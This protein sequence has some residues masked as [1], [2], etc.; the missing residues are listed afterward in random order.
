[1]TP[2]LMMGVMWLMPPAAL[3]LSGP[4]RAWGGWAC[5]AATALVWLA[6]LFLVPG[7]ERLRW[8]AAGASSLGACLWAGIVVQRNAGEAVRLSEALAQ[9]RATAAALTKGLAA[10]KSRSKDVEVEQREVHALYGM[11]KGMAEV[12]T[13]DGVRPKLEAAVEQYLRVEEFAVYVVEQK[14]S[15]A[16]RLLARRRLSGSPGATW[17]TLSRWM[18]E[19]AVAMTVA[20]VVDKPERAVA[21]PIFESEKLIGYFYARIPREADAEAM[22]MRAQ[23]FVEE[24]SFAFRRIKLFQEVEKFSLV[25][26][27]TGAYRRR[28]LDERLAEEVVRAQTFKTTFCL[29][30]LDIDKFKNLNDSYGHQFGDEVLSRVGEILRGS[31]YE[32]D[33]V[34]RYGGEEFAILLPRA[35]PAGVLRKAEALRKAIETASFELAMQRVS[36]TISLG[37]AHYPRDG[38]A[39]DAIVRQADRALYHAKDTGRNRVVDVAEIPRKA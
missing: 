6:G 3:W 16:M 34:A 15:D 32:T 39:A 23:T 11:V 21:V 27:L 30:L 25:D 24:I 10:A 2:E 20:R 28:V 38:A 19:N 22:L 9:R 31:V 8:A 4:T 14:A 13:W 33:F 26:G 29:M 1:M 35:E 36:V 17:D 12:M 7:A 37:I 5:S 18:Q